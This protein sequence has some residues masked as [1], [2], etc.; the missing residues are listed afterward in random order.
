M[1]WWAFALAS[2]SAAAATA[3]TDKIGVEHV[4]SNLATAVRTWSCSRVRAASSLCA[5]NTTAGGAGTRQVGLLARR[6]GRQSEDLEW[7]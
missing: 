2:A 4:R 5:A 3:R 1:P 6:A 7:R